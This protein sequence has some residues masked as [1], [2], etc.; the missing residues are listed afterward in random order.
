MTRHLDHKLNFNKNLLFLTLASI[1][2][3]VLPARAQN[4]PAR[5]Q[6][7]QNL[8]AHAQG[9]AGAWQ[10]MTEVW[11]RTILKISKS[12]SGALKADMYYID[13][14]A[15]RYPV[16]DVTFDSSTLQ[17]PWTGNT[18][19][20]VGK[21]SAD[22]NTIVGA[23]KPENRPSL[24]M[25]F[26]RATPETAWAIPRP[27]GPTAMAADAHPSFEVATIKPSA[28]SE[29]NNDL[30]RFDNEGRHFTADN[31]SLLRLIQYA[32][33]L[34]SRQILDARAWADTT[35]FDIAGVPDTPGQ[36]NWDQQRE[37]YQK[38]L[39]DRFRLSIHREKKEFPVYALRLGKN[40]LKLTKRNGDPEDR[41]Y[42]FV[43]SGPHGG[44]T[45]TYVNVTMKDFLVSLMS[46]DVK[47]RQVVDQTGLT[48]RYDFS[49][50]YA[51]DILAPNAGTAP[52]IFHAVQQQLGL[53]LVPTKAPVEVIVI[54]HVE[55]PSL[56]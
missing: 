33:Q 28:P 49:L 4:L 24:P 54:E 36:P 48:G 13:R 21:M 1:S 26:T 14:G 53:K 47:D 37:M 10:S 22:G 7:V 38:L 32:Y 6:D 55:R 16:N 29:G 35:K 27:A 30:P 50:T 20:Y 42:G 18:G 11:G 5:T 52:D 12:D 25:T 44:V 2:L 23:W 56:N 51:S 19:N 34:Q 17:F 3:G 9:I 39:E 45:F 8:P 31:V 40:G 15:R 46:W 41:E 43:N